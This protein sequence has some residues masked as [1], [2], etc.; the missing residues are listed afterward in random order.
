MRANMRGSIRSV[1]VIDSA[2]EPPATAASMRRRSGRFSDQNSASLSS[3]SKR[4]T[5]SHFAKARILISCTDAFSQ[6]QRLIHFALI[7]KLFFR[8]E[9]AGHENTDH[10]A[11]GAIDAKDADARGGDAQVK[12]PG[13]DA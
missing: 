13:L 6:L 1:M 5:S 4:G 10:T 7:K 8:F 11:I 3:L 9:G 2:S 12:E